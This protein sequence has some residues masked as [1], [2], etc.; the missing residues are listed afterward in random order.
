MLGFGK[1]EL[2]KE[3]VEIACVQEADSYFADEHFFNEGEIDFLLKFENPLELISDIWSN[4]IGDVSQTVNA[5]FADQERTLQKGGYTL[6]SDDSVP[7][8]SAPETKREAIDNGGK[9]SVLARIRQHTQEQRERPVV[10]KEKS[11]HKKTETEL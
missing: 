4:R 10:P 3:A 8:F 9:P 6:V 11:G 5:I 1:E 2:F 7:T